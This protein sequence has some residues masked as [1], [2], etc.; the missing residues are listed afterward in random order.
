MHY[1]LEL[2]NCR[3]VTGLSLKAVSMGLPQLQ[4]IDVGGSFN[5]Q[6]K[7]I[8]HLLKYHPNTKKQ[9][10]NEIYASGLGW[11]ETTLSTLL[12]YTSSFLRGL[13]IG[14]SPLLHNG[15]T[16]VSLLSSCGSTLERLGLH[17]IDCVD[18]VV[19]GELGGVLKELCVLDIRG[20]GGVSS[21]SGM[22][23][24]RFEYGFENE[25]EDGN[26]DHDGKK[27]K[28]KKKDKKKKRNKK[29][30]SEGGSGFDSEEDD[31]NNEDE[32]F[33]K[34]QIE[35]M[36][37]RHLFVLA[38]YSG[39]AKKSLEETRRIH[40]YVLQERQLKDSSCGGGSSSNSA[41]LFMLEL[42]LTCVL[43]GEGTGV[44]IRR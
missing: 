25:E 6:P 22:M 30:W 20:C 29:G 18:N 35:E 9:L 32:G 27:M 5:I 4:A 33:G 39:I 8:L 17:F 19:L 12:S 24:T 41:P 37:Q 13:S 7:D 14:F 21:L 3:K 23:E 43:D 40:K 16:L 31:N 11:N 10:L 34:Q 42:P 26:H 38:R 1:T 44:G 36:H 28:K 2:K 15:S